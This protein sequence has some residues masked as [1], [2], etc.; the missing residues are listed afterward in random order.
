M[1]EFAGLKSALSRGST[2]T[3]FYVVPSS[4]PQQMHILITH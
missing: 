2:A 1:L 4:H 3:Q